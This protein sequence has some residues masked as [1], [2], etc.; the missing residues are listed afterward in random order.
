MRLYTTAALSAT[1]AGLGYYLVTS[2]AATTIWTAT[3]AV[4]PYS[5]RALPVQQRTCV[6]KYCIMCDERPGFLT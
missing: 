6:N 3:R 5:D 1:Y 2:N 4:W